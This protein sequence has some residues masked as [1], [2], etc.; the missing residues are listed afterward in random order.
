MGVLRIAKTVACGVFL[1]LPMAAWA[2]TSS[3][4]TT[5]SATATKVRGTSGAA[6]AGAT[7][8]LAQQPTSSSPASPSL[9][10]EFFRTEVQP[11]FL[12]KRQGFTRCYVC[13]TNFPVMRLQPLPPGR[14]TWNE[15]Q[16]RKNFETVRRMV[17]PGSLKSRLLVHPLA[18][19]AGGDLWHF[20]GKHWNNQN[21]PDWQTI[22]AWVRGEKAGGTFRSSWPSS[23]ESREVFTRPP[24]NLR[25]FQTNHSGDTISIIDP[26]TNS[27]VGEI[28]GIE[29]CHGIAVAPD[30][31]RIYASN[32][33][34]DTLDVVDGRTLKVVKKISLSGFP[35]NIAITPDGRRV[36]VGIWEAP[37]AVDVINTISLTRVKSIP[38]KGE[39]HNIYVT[40]DGKHVVPGSEQGTQITVIDTQ[41]EQP[42]WELEFDA[43]VRPMAIEPNPD[44]STKRIFVQLSDL[45]GFAVVDFG[46]RKEVT[47]INLP[48][49]P[50]GGVP[51]RNRSQGNISH[52]IG[53]AP[54]GKT[55][56]V[57][58]RL[59]N[60]VYAYS[61][62]DLEL[63]GGVATGMA[64]NWL[65][66]TPDSRTV[67]VANEAS[68]TVSVVDVKSM[69]EVVQI[70]VGSVPKRNTTGVL[71]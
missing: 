71:P 19:E 2:Q 5:G 7:A 16:S 55:L 8:S 52:G 3:D 1:F 26:A 48:E 25:V 28:Q 63:L 33:A 56:W 50:S 41:T 15:E 67:Y 68:D 18:P 4:S 44:G 58:S 64:P 14:T 34:D 39:V 49:L 61:L 37:G 59:N 20:G 54:D 46:T 51:N 24:S 17:V 42:V 65:T 21:N 45:H 22:A 31:S 62:P 57:N 13:H 6:L 35:N 10:F 30:G 38:V 69:K 27:V 23:D 60:H 32:E 66:I 70:P 11:I 43:G 12:K 40:P 29:A 53:V 47:R 36:Y 9:D